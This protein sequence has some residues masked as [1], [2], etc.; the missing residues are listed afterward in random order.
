MGQHGLRRKLLADALDLVPPQPRRGAL[1]ELVLCLPPGNQ[2]LQEL[3]VGHDILH[4]ARKPHGCR[5]RLV[6]SEGSEHRSC[7]QVRLDERRALVAY[8]MEQPIFASF[9]M[10]LE[11]G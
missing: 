5:W 1:P 10:E 7:G 9:S 11:L 8:D 3:A 6:L 4:V 2:R